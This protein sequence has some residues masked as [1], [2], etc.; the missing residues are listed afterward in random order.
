MAGEL[1]VLAGRE[2]RTRRVSF[3]L[4]FLSRVFPASVSGKRP[5]FI[6]R[7]GTASL[8][9]VEPPDVCEAR[10]GGEKQVLLLIATVPD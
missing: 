9:T 2:L 10:Y 6:I 7:S 8:Q 1:W 3:S 5:R 4:T